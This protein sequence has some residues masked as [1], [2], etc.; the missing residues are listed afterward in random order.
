MLQRTG[1]IASRTPT[2]GTYTDSFVVA[3]TTTGR[4]LAKQ[5]APTATTVFN[6]N[7]LATSG[8]GT[9]CPG[10]LPAAQIHGPGQRE[11]RSG[12][13]VPTRVTAALS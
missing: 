1:T 12:L 10:V 5:I 6:T 8:R 9:A 4:V 13:P 3:T 11:V 2:P 7:F